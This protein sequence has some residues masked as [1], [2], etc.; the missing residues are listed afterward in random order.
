[1]C[2]SDLAAPNTG[3][4]ST[5]QFVDLGLVLK[6]TPVVH[7]D[8]EITLDV[9]A[10]FKTLGSRSV[11]GIPEIAS[12][13]YQGK[14]RLKGGQWGVIAGL[15]S[16]LESDSNNGV[17]GLAKIPGLGRRVRERDLSET[18]I[19]LKPRIV[20]LPPWDTPTPSLWTGTE[21]RPRTF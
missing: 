19:V 14:V 15:V 17:A 16:T 21:T 4:F 8:Y 11:N 13:Q 7:E 2:S 1:M 20:S 5:V 9:D 10:E 3:Q 18:W 6:V 12:R